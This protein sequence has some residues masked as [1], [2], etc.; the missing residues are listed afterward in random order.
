MCCAGCQA[1]AEAIIAC[2]GEDYYLRRHLPAQNGELLPPPLPDLQALEHPLMQRLY[3]EES[4]RSHSAQLS[5]AGMSCAACAWLIERRLQQLPGLIE[6]QANLTSERLSVRY[7]DPLSL[8]TIIAAIEGIGY[9]ASPFQIQ[10]NSSLQKQEHREMLR[11]AIAGLGALQAMMFAMGLYFGAWEN[12]SDVHRDFL[13]LITF[14]VATPV[15]FY[16]GWPF[17]KRSILGLR[18][19]Q[20]NMDLPLSLAILISYMASVYAMLKGQG[21]TYFDSISMLIFI[22]SVSR[23]LE[24]RARRRA[25]DIQ[26]NMSA[27]APRL[28]W[29]IEHDQVVRIASASANPGDLLLV[30]TG[31]RIP[32][33]GILLDDSAELDE[34][35][36][37]GESLPV[38]KSSG[39]ALVCGSLNLG[40]AL[41]IQV[42]AS[43]EASSLAQLQKL[44]LDAAMDKPRLALFADRIAGWVVLALLLVAAGSY[45]YWQAHDPSR[46]LWNT[47]A[48]LVATCP[49][50]LSLAI[51]VALISATGALA[52]AGLLITRGHVLE[53]L[54]DCDIVVFDKT[55]TLTTAQLQVAEVKALSVTREQALQLACALEAE[56]SHP[57][58]QAFQ[59]LDVKPAYGLEERTQHPSLGVSASLAGLTYR[60]GQ[61]AFIDP[62]LNLPAE[63]DAEMLWLALARGSEIIAWIGL[64][65]HLRAQ[66]QAC[67]EGLRQ[68]GK[69]V[70]ILSGDQPERVASCARALAIDAADQQA[71]LQPENKLAALRQLQAQGHRIMVVGDGI[72][73]API[74]AQAD[75]SI[76]MGQGSDLARAQADALLVNSRLD[77]LVAAVHH[78]RRCLRITREN[79]GWALLY[80][81]I[82]VPLAATGQVPPYIAALGMSTSSMIVVLNALR[83]RQILPQK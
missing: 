26:N 36:L 66:A 63:L 24:L 28:A 45:F 72:N 52:R 41:K 76:A 15:V 6:A 78:A 50:A 22:V 4:G 10:E 62:A 29:R 71:R 20:L 7:A 21:E 14:V 39:Q 3:V 40:Q 19:R 57:I 82:I 64:Q 75:L 11:L 12:I 79:L 51:P 60:L 61:P 49:C 47:V 27:L 48:V 55:G 81:I 56:A 23:F 2:G 31:E 38:H 37:S 43:G 18:H 53:G 83:L 35:L 44:L 25:G 5:L 77:L 59:A 70:M 58:A 46:A 8:A 54:V 69:R 32:C 33:D 65:D 80:N 42:S 68:A 17:Y 9:R 30:K 1:V 74:L 16:A 67:V 13:R 73:D 34:S